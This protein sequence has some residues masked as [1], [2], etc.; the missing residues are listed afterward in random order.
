MRQ[1]E[2]HLTRIDLSVRGLTQ[3]LLGLL[4][5]PFGLIAAVLG[6]YMANGEAHHDFDEGIPLLGF[7]FGCAI[8][9]SVS[10]VRGALNLR[11]RTLRGPQNVAPGEASSPHPE[12]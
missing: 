12:E 1:R 10:I 2:V 8:V 3:I 6:G 5:V 4:L 11:R 9:G 7:G